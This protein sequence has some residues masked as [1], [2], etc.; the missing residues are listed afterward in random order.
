MVHWNCNMYTVYCTGLRGW[1][2]LALAEDTFWFSLSFSG[3]WIHVQ[4][5]RGCWF[6]LVFNNCLMVWAT[7]N[8]NVYLQGQL[9]YCS[10]REKKTGGPSLGK[11]DWKLDQFRTNASGETPY[12]LIWRANLVLRPFSMTDDGFIRSRSLE[13]CSRVVKIYYKKNYAARSYLK[14]TRLLVVHSFSLL[15]LLKAIIANHN[16]TWTFL[17][18]KFFSLPSS[19][20][21]FFFLAISLA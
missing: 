17:L 13:Q 2:R 4:A 16:R 18:H 19:L 7:T 8:P 12:L 11:F 10:S 3:D 5:N 21:E 20:Q 1:S 15:K 14:I 6:C 9:L